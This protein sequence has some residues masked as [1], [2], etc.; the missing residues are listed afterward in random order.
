MR[1]L[2]MAALL[3]GIVM[4][5]GAQSAPV[6]PAATT[7]TL[8]LPIAFS[9]EVRSRTEWDAPGGPVAA[10]L[11][12]M[13]RS[14]FGVRVEPA[15]GVSL[16]LQ[17]QDSRVLGTEGNR[18][19]STTDVFDL[20]QG[21][22][23]LATPWRGSELAVRAGR[24]EI[25]LGNE[26][27]VG[28]VNWSNTGRTFDGAR[29]ALAPPG[30]GGTD[31]WMGTMFAAIM[32]ENGRRFGGAATGTPSLR[33]HFVAGAYA[34][35]GAPQ[36]S[37]V[38]FTLLFDAGARYRTFIDADRT[39]LDTRVHGVAPLGVRVELEGAVQ[40][41]SQTLVPSTGAPAGQRVRAW[42]LGARV[43][44]TTGRV[45]TTFGLDALSGDDTP[46]DD[47]YTAFSTMYGTNHPYYGL[48]DVLGDPA[49]T[50]KERGLRDMFGALAMP[51]GTSFAP[52]AELHRFALATG[53]DRRL[54]TEA[55][56]VAPIR[57]TAGTSIELGYALFRNGPAAA[58]L[59]LGADGAYR[60]WIYAQLRAGF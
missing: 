33:D 5:L 50:T 20:H 6:Q 44:R 51:I 52:R 58:P 32:E 24:Q 10:D 21:F 23:Q 26:R 36:K 3:T 46:T 53:D 14:R 39:T 28:A 48:M 17:L 19:S 55:D 35:V 54:G 38:D 22:L 31:Q 57:L 13:L 27:L 60:K 42:L 25:A 4:P 45:T 29:I 47:R 43:A 56:L 41:G 37:G 12:T 18:V 11:F 59:G 9:G 40:G 1:T 7:G 15:R 16:V 8:A 2:A 49:T 34:S 30:P